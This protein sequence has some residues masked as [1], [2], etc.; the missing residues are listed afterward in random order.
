MWVEGGVAGVPQ[1]DVPLL[2]WRPHLQMPQP[3]L[4]FQHLQ[5]QIRGQ[6]PAEVLGPQQQGVIPVAGPVRCRHEYLASSEEGAEILVVECLLTSGEAVGGGPQLH[7]VRGQFYKSQAPCQGHHHDHRHRQD[8]QWPRGHPCAPALEPAAEDGVGGEAE[9]VGQADACL[10]F[11]RLALAP[12]PLGQTGPHEEGRE[13][14]KE[15]AED[16]DEGQAPFHPAQAEG[17]VQGLG[18]GNHGAGG[19]TVLA[20]TGRCTIPLGLVAGH[21]LII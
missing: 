20:G 6:D 15:T 13:Q 18:L 2:I 1:G 14:D 17:G 19:G 4:Q 21:D 5:Q 3:L 9:P 12:A 8:G 16:D 10:G 7:R 11:E